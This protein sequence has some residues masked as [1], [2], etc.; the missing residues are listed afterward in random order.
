MSDAV[1][2]QVVERL[3]PS[4]RLWLYS[5]E[6][7]RVD[8]GGWRAGKTRVLCTAGVLLSYL[9]PDNLGFIGRASAKDLG[10]TTIKT[11]F[12]EVCP[13]GLIVGKPKRVGQSGLEATLR[14]RYPNRYSKVYF[15]YIIDKQSGKSHLAGGNWGWFG[16]DQMEEIQRGD[17]HKLMGRLSRTFIDPKDNIRKP[18]RTHALGVGNQQGH[19]WIFEDFFEGGDYV[20]DPIK[21]PKKFFKTVSRNRRLG[22]IVRSE[23]NMISNGGFVPDQYYEN[24]RRN[25][26]R[27]WIARYMDGSFDDFSGKIYGD[28]SLDSVHNI[29]PF[30]I[31]DHWP[32]GGYIDPGGSAPWAIGH[33]F[34]DEAGNKIIV[35]SFDDVY[36]ASRM[37]PNQATAAIKGGFDIQK[38]RFVI[39]YQNVPVTEH[40]RENDIHCEPAMKDIKVGVNGAISAFYIQPERHLPD[41]FLQTQPKASVEKF[42]G[43]GSPQI[44]VFKTCKSWRKE[45]DNWIWDPKRPN[46]PK[47]GANHHCDGTRYWLASNP[48]PAEGLSLDPRA[49]YR[50][51]DPNSAK[52]GDWI[53]REVSRLKA[54]DEMTRV[55]NSDPCDGGTYDPYA[56]SEPQFVD[57]SMIGRYGGW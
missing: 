35:D 37:S 24:L 15:D 41:W 50:V 46:I 12:D 18:I 26:P 30:K 40:F 9:I 19:D 2:E 55:R 48:Q 32:S 43:K 34:T 4:Q 27:E 23:E 28:Y 36:G 17:W 7:E 31:P 25:M 3:L 20:F 38:T 21:E 44:F 10:S 51:T 8:M 14:T 29:E 56:G 53:S 33:G 5:P 57:D 22:V 13:P 16:V 52:H 45:H 42:Q 6:F 39:D 1:V 49:K 47:D 11:F 54:K